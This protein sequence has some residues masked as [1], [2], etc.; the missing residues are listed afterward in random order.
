L[1]KLPSD[2]VKGINAVYGSLIIDGSYMRFSPI[3]ENTRGD[4]ATSYSPWDQIYNMG[5]FNMQSTGDGVLFSWTAYYQGILR[6][7]EVLKYVPAI[8]NMDADL[9]KR[10]L[11]QAYFLRALYYFHLA[12]FYKNVPMPLGSCCIKRRLFPEAATA[13]C[14][15]GAGDQRF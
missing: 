1:A 10:V 14:C 5:K 4:D 13:G 6:A 7:N 11:G 12:D 9:K 8:T 3:V 2:A 15:L